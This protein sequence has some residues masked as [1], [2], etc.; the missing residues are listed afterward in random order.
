METRANELRAET[1][2]ARRLIIERDD[3]STAASL[4]IA[5]QPDSTQVLRFIDKH[6]RTRISMEISDDDIAGLT[7]CDANETPRAR[8]VVAA[9]GQPTMMVDRGTRIIRQTFTR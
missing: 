8:I 6:G 5:T 1:V 4:E 9:D 2:R 7:V 3:G